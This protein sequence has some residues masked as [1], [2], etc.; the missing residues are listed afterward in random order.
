MTRDTAGG[1]GG[2][3]LRARARWAAALNI[4]CAVPAG[5]SVTVLQKSVVRGDAAAT[6]AN[7]LGSEGV[8]RLGFVSDLVAI[9][10]FVA[11]A[12]LLYEIF[13]PA[14]RRSALL[15]LVLILMGAA[16]QALECIQD[17]AA[18][19][20]VKGG[21]GMSALPSAQANALAFMFLRLH[22]F[23]YVLALF[24]IGCS[25]VVMG[26]L[27]LRSTFVPRILGPL[28]MIDGLGYL[29]F[30][31][32]SFLSPPVAAHIYPY[33]PFV[34]ALLGEGALFLWL[35]IKSVNAER[36][37]EQAAATDRAALAWP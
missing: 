23:N 34:T 27:L 22:S 1:S 20:L 21:A 31:L 2:R 24:F 19:V 37:R 18:L 13:R 8:F 30:S 7:V 36:W 9:L 32:A 15:F 3:S 12:V 14:G 28:M 5:F 16:F 6:A 35:I 17:L 10:I 4:L 33:V 25:S 26:H 11:S 29:T